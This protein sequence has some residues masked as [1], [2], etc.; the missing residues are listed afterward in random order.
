MPSPTPCS[1]GGSLAS[2]CVARDRLEPVPWPSRSSAA[3]RRSGRRCRRGRRPPRSTSAGPGRRSSTSRASGRTAS[4][5][6]AII[7][8]ETIEAS[9]TMTRSCGSRFE[10]P[11][12]KRLRLP[13]RQPSRR[14]MVEALSAP[15]SSL[16]DSAVVDARRPPLGPTPRGA[17]PPFRSAPTSATRGGA[18]S[19][20]LGLLADEGRDP[21]DGG[22]LAG[23]R[24][25]GDDREP[26]EHR[27]RGGQRLQA[28]GLAGEEATEAVREN[29][30]VDAVDLALR[31]G[32]GGRRRA[33]PPGASSGRGRG[34][35]R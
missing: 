13:G 7:E 19:G 15:S 22:R 26:V 16:T 27:R 25:A 5:M 18:R 8:S 32:A 10:R 24:A 3:R 20:G 12:R 9:S 4:T 1:A 17:P 30:V 29:V 33:R 11:W 35:R 23:P 6:L 31:A 34:G 21:R 2:T 28:V 14:C